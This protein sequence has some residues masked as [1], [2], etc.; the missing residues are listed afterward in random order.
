[1]VAEDLKINLAFPCKV[2]D[3]VLASLIK[4]QKLYRFGRVHIGEL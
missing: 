2:Q 4:I 3:S 1:M